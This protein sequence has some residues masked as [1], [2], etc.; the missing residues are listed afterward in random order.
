M[1]TL[2]PEIALLKQQVLARFEGHNVP[3]KKVVLFCHHNCFANYLDRPIEERVNFIINT[4]PALEVIERLSWIQPYLGHPKMKVLDITWKKTY[5]IYKESCT[6]LEKAYK[7][8]RKAH[9]V[10]HQT[11][12]SY[13]KVCAARNKAYPGYKKADAACTKASTMQ[14][15]AYKM[16]EKAYTPIFMSEHPDCPWDG[17]TLDSAV[18]KAHELK[19]AKETK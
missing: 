9:L 2:T 8:W 7:L 19:A 3:D 15:K 1:H 4:K 13:K 17:K 6:R 11:Y 16:W 10:Y 14:Q 5:T 18:T 12:S